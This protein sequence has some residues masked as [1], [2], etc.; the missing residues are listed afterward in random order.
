MIR[1]IYAKIFIWFWLAMIGVA[2]SVVVIALALGAEPLGRRWISRTLDYYGRSSVDFYEHGGKPLLQEYLDDIQRS[3][4][5]RAALFDPSG[6]NILGRSVPLGGEMALEEARASGKSR[7]LIGLR[8]TGASVVSTPEGNFI[9]VAQVLPLRGVLTLSAVSSFLLRLAIALLSAGLLCLILARHISAPIRSLQAAARRIA[10]GDLNVRALPTIPARNDE[11]SELAQDFDRMAERIQQLLLKQQE[12]LGDISHELRSPL[13]R[14]GVSLELVRRGETDGVE[15]MQ[16]DLDRLDALIGQILTLTR[17]GSDTGQKTEGNVNLRS[18]VE[19]V[20]E[21]ACFE[22]K[23]NGRTVEIKQA[24]EC[25]LWGDPLLLRSCIENV[26]RNAVRYTKPQTAVAISL[27]LLNGAGSMQAQILVADHG[28]GVPP[29]A[30][31]R[32]FEPFYR[33]SPSRDR[34]SGGA[35]LGLS[36]AQRVVML[37]GGSIS[38]RNREGGGLEMEL[39]IPASRSAHPLQGPQK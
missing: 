35:G 7:V 37:H 33:V 30:L 34:G 22:G 3:S 25:W 20:A 27:R 29:E 6:N 15:H 24:D 1:S 2:A 31:P 18:I 23:E 4:G 12:L 9:L 16:A 17:L 14:L 28:D 39:R 5:I 10:D 13:A 26:V 38:A 11:L 32:L 8:W 21:D 36:I 19:S